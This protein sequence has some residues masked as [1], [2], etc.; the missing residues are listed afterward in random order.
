V[1]N[2]GVVATQGSIT[3]STVDG[4]SLSDNRLTLFAKQLIFAI[5]C[6]ALKRAIAQCRCRS[7]GAKII[8][9]D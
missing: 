1:D 3:F 5:A 9:V 8:H 4:M 6:A 2:D 7:S